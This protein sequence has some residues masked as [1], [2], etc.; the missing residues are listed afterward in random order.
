M[1]CFIVIEG[2]QKNNGKPPAANSTSFILEQKGYAEWFENLIQCFETA[3]QKKIEINDAS[4]RPKNRKHLRYEYNN[5]TIVGI[6]NKTIRIKAQRK[7]RNVSSQLKRNIR[8]QFP[9]FTNYMNS[10]AVKATF[11]LHYRKPSEF[12]INIFMQGSITHF[13][14][15]ASRVGLPDVT[16]L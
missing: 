1:K 4:L 13:E 2:V 8:I 9:G 15:K 5:V 3:G 7:S 16:E 12:T 14:L 10:C 11:I 6:I